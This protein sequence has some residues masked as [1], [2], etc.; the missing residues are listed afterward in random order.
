M[1]QKHLISSAAPNIPIF[2]ETLG[3]VASELSS[4]TSMMT[5]G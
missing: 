4:T 1:D 5:Y 3:L 2:K